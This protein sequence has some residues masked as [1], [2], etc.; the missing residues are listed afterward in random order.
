[1][2]PCRCLQPD[3]SCFFTLHSKRPAKHFWYTL[4]WL[5]GQTR[6]FWAIFIIFLPRSIPHPDLATVSNDTM[7]LLDLYVC[8]WDVDLIFPLPL[9]LT[10]CQILHGRSLSLQPVPLKSLRRGLKDNSNLANMLSDTQ[11]IF[12][13]PDYCPYLAVILSSFTATRA[14]PSAPFALDLPLLP[15]YNGWP[16]EEAIP[17]CNRSEE[18]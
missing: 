9:V 2:S 16:I 7:S 10:C 3:L 13:K 4:L 12:I 5:L 8:K 11:V 18:V 14:L 6:I 1:M 15:E 17:I